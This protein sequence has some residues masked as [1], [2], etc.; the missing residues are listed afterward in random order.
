[1][2][3]VKTHFQDLPV[4]LDPAQRLE[5]AHRH[6]DVCALPIWQQ[7]LAWCDRMIGVV[8]L[9]TTRDEHGRPSRGWIDRCAVGEFLFADCYTDRITQDRTLPHRNRHSA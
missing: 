6:F 2:P 5:I 3:A 4:A 7:L 8:D 9:L 1:M